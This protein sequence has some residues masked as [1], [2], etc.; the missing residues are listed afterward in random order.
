MREIATGLT[1]DTTLCISLSGRPGNTGTRFHNWLYDALGLDFV[2]KAFTTTDI[3]AAIAG[4][5]GLGIRGCAVSMPWKSD[6]IALVDELDASAR[7]IDSVNTIVN[8]DGRLVAHNTDYVAVASLLASHRVPADRAAAVLGS[9]GMAKATVAAL[10]DAGFGDVTVVARNEASG[11]ALAQRYGCAWAPELGD[12]RPAT[13]V[14]CTPV[15]M[16]GG[17]EASDLP[18]PVD[19]VAAADVVF[20]MVPMP[21]RTPLIEAADARGKTI[22]TGAEVMSLQALEQ[23]VLYTGVRP[24]PALVAEATAFS[25]LS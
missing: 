25:R 14:N 9:G 13:L 6:V 15:G 22:I 21:A 11:A 3:A 8:T 1:K 4:V 5:R 23:F 16:A 2:Y 24:D 17:P 7:A 20:D 19:A 12:V 18:V 10:R